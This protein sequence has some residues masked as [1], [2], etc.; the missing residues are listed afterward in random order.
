MTCLRVAS[1][2]VDSANVDEIVRR[3]NDDLVPIYREQNGFESLSVASTGDQIVSVSRWASRGDAEAAAPAIL[4]WV[5]GQ[6]DILNPPTASHIG[7]EVMS[8]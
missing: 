3:A 5:K 6:S 8:A 2:P 7:D 4:D 1:Y